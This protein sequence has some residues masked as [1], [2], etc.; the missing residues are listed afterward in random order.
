MESLL[1]ISTLC[2]LG[3]VTTWFIFS[4]IF[5]RNDIMDIAW[6]I[7]YILLCGLYTQIAETSPRAWLLY[8]LVLIWGLRLSIHICLR[9]K[10]KT[11]DFRY[12]Q[13]RNDWGKWFY[14]RS[15]G[16][17][18][19]LQGFLL[20]LI[21]SPITISVTQPSSPLSLINYIG[22]G[23]WITGFF[24]ESIGD[25]QLTK[26]K[27]NPE[28]KGKIIQNGLWKY[29]RHPNYFGEVTLWWGIWMVSLGNIFSWL[30]LVGPLTITIL[31]LFVS[32]IPML[33]KKYKGNREFENYK[34][35]TSPFFPLP[36][37]K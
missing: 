13:W 33:E 9:N 11:E 29:T 16:Q 21:I 22:V 8:L 28:N 24:F 14:I 7:G 27:S 30:S 26:F 5:K 12:K 6:G 31:I 36:Q 15:Y 10:G 4:L 3:Y 23:V 25:T 2:V 34:K 32:G 37:K 35:R 20:L 18:Y 19:L 1:L 17:I